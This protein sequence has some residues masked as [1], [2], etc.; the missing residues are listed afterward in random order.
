MCIV[1]NK[2]CAYNRI[3]LVHL[4]WFVILNTIV[5]PM[6]CSNVDLDRRYSNI[7]FLQKNPFYLQYHYIFGKTQYI[8]FEESR[9]SGVKFECIARVRKVINELE[10]ITFYC[11]ILFWCLYY[12]KGDVIWITC[13]Q[14]T[15][16]SYI[17]KG[18]EYPTD[19]F[20]FCFSFL[21]ADLS[22]FFYLGN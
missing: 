11:N 22:L 16:Y 14:L 18:S 3:S 10:F 20:D 9:R 19:C 13:N 8:I 12:G 21:F 2:L 6:K 4:K 17:S 15:L 5:I 7:H 1:Y